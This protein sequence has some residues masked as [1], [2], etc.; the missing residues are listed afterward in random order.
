MD[1]SERLAITLTPCGLIMG[2]IRELT[3]T[4]GLLDGYELHKPRAISVV[5][6]APGTACVAV[7]DVI[8][9]PDVLH[10]PDT[11]VWYTPT[12]SNAINAYIQSTSGITIAKELPRAAR[13]N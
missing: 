1:T 6:G 2:N 10:L 13:A 5:P 9:K 12:D 11:I 4:D 8:G 7:S 3:G